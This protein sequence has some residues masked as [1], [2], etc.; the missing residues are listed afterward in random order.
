M[1]SQRRFCSKLGERQITV[2]LAVDKI[3][4]G[5]FRARHMP[6][7]NIAMHGGQAV[8][9]QEDSSRMACCLSLYSVR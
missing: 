1:C 4:A 7:G 9:G 3:A 5:L 2:I 8:R 6:M